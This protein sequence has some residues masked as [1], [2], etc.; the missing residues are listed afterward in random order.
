MVDDTAEA[1]EGLR[2]GVGGT[3]LARLGDVLGWP[4]WRYR[5]HAEPRG[6][7]FRLRLLVTLG[8]TLAAVGALGY[9]LIAGQLRRDQIAD[10]SRTQRSD[11]RV[12]EAIGRTVTDPA[13]QAAALARAV[14]AIGQRP[15]TTEALLIS[16]RDVV[17]ASKSPGALGTVDP[18]PRIAE[19]LMNGKPYSGLDSDPGRRRDYG[20]LIAVNL[21]DGQY[22]F[23]TSFDHR[24][25]DRSL[26]HLRRSLGLMWLLALAIGGV[27]FYLVGGR[28]LI[29]SHR[30]ALMRA[31][32][33]GLTD[34]P[35]HRSFREELAAGIGQAV[36]YQ[37]PISLLLVDIDDFRLFNDCHGHVRGDELLIRVSSVLRDGRPGDR[38]F[39]IGGDE[40]ALL[41]PK[42]DGDGALVRARRLVRELNRS[43]ERR[44]HTHA[45]TTAMV[46]GDCGAKLV[47]EPAV[48]HIKGARVSMVDA[49]PLP[50]RVRARDP[51]R[52]DT[53]ELVQRLLG[54]RQ[55]HDQLADVV[56]QSG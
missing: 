46:V 19:A 16:P 47:V 53:R 38:A 4:R 43:G 5:T 9:I 20:F 21:P 50:L 3:V 2:L 49:E 51:V 34:L 24:T 12:L 56:Q 14:S 28:A 41:L 40:F 17:V 23:Q 52:D 45:A 10:Y 7:G 30:I 11:A 27:V 18:D 39:R 36:R 33:D 22:A 31:T 15:G 13:T 25:L 44:W 48:A 42:T 35:N 1:V 32:R 26:S 55:W 37:E 6:L 54:E 8:A 29:R